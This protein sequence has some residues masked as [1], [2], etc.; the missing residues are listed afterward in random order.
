MIYTISVCGS[1]RN[2]AD[3]Q[4]VLGCNAGDLGDLGSESL[5]A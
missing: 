3:I 1:R 5:P 4:P 2:L